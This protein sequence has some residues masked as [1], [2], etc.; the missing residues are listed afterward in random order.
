MTTLQIVNQSGKYAIRRIGRFRTMYLERG[1]DGGW[2]GTPNSWCWSDLEDTERMYDHLVDLALG[3]S[4][5]KPM[6]VVKS[7]DL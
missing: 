7:T 6:V 1:S 3:T 4:A 5:N 2:V